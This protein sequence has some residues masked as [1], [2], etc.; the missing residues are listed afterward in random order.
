[1]KKQLSKSYLS[2]EKTKCENTASYWYY[3]FLYVI[4]HLCLSYTIYDF[5][6]EL[7]QRINILLFFI[8][9]II[10]SFKVNV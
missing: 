9:I 8:I 1:M 5:V 6:I 4:L 7:L 10:I 2:L 3:F